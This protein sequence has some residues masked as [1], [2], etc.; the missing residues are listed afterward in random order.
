MDDFVIF[1]RSFAA[2]MELKDITFALLG[3]LGLSIHPT[4]GYHTATQ[5]GEH[6]GMT[7]DNK[8]NEFRAPKTK[9]DNIA[10]AATKLLVRAT[11]NNRW[12]PIK[13]LASIAR[14]SYFLYLVIPAAMF[15]LWELHDVIKT[16]ESWTWT[17]RM[18]KQLKRVPEWWKAVPGEHDRAPIFKAMETAYLHCDS[19]DYGREAFLND[20][21]EARG[22]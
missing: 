22:L 6:L 5:E 1:A 8:K 14:K 4:K 20:C 16:T 18:T 13:A 15:Y 7:I 3:E 12:V 19:S 17:V 11:H 21:V 9:L 10:S 2:A